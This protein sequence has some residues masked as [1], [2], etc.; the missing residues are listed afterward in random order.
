[1]PQSAGDRAAARTDELARRLAELQGRGPITKEDVEL[2]AQ[3]AE[4]SR[5]R[6]EAAHRSAAR[7]HDQSADLH[8]RAAQIH[9]RAQ[10][11]RVGEATAQQH[12]AQQHRDAG[13]PPKAWR[14][15]L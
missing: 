3:H 5:A 1:M 7:R 12:A 13:Y 14:H 15:A 2:A 4:E 6:A 9:E 11:S 10:A 8:E